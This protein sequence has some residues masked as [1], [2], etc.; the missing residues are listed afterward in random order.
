M[1]P[2]LLYLYKL[3]FLH[4]AISQN[5]H[6]RQLNI[7]Y[8]KVH[9][10]KLKNN[11]HYYKQKIARYIYNNKHYSKTTDKDIYIYKICTHFLEFVYIFYDYLAVIY[12][13]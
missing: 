10:T 5:K 7:S 11:V 12:K 4:I 3:T 13:T 6:K 9:K 1:F 2:F 8:K